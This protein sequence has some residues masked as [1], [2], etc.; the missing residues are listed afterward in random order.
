[1]VPPPW[2]VAPPPPPPAR[3]PILGTFFVLFA[4]VFL[5]TTCSTC[6][7]MQANGEG[8]FGPS[9]PKVG[10]VEVAGTIMTSKEIVQNLAEFARNEE[11]EAVVLRVDSPGGSVGPSQEIFEAVRRTA[12]VKPVIASMGSVAA[13]GGFWVSL[14]ADEIFANPGTITG[15]IGVI[16]QT[17]DLR[18]IAQLLKFQMRTYK[19]GPHKDLGSP[20]REPSPGDEEIFNTLVQDI[21]QQFVELTAE[22][23]K[24]PVEVVKKVADGRIFTGR[25]AHS[26][27]LIDGM[28]GLET[29]AR[30]A[31]A[32]AEDTDTSTDTF[33]DEAPVLI[34]P[35]DPLPPIFELLGASMGSAVSDGLATGVERGV[36][37]LSEPAVELR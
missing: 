22:R 23:R 4:G 19:S 34:Y 33:G 2:V 12:S 29:A 8:P 17:P 11:I 18:G 31:L 6:A 14:G 3:F 21:Y 1:M 20:F 37:A 15:S 27:G 10:V 30:R 28:G 13:S 24:L 9:G 25:D 35:K 36:R 7:T 32:I 16:V 5:G 26:M